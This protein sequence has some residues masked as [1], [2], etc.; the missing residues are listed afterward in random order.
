VNVRS[1]VWRALFD[2]LPLKVVSLIL[3]VTLFVIVRSDKDAA[4]GAFVKVVY[5]LPTDRVL[6]S[7]PPS[8]IKVAIRGS[9][10]RLQRFDEREI[11]PVRIDLSHLSD[12]VLRFDADLI[13][14][15]VGLRVGSIYPS[16]VRL[17]YEPRA[18]REVP[19]QAL[20]EGT[21]AEGFH[22]TQVRAVPA[23]IRIDGARR[24]VES[25]RRAPTRPV[26][27]QDAT[28]S[29][30]SPVAL[31]AP[32]A[33]VHFV[34][35]GPVTVE[36]EIRAAIIERTL[37]AVPVRLSGAQRI[38]GATDPQAVRVILRG[39]ADAVQKVDPAQ[40]AVTVEARV[41]DGRPPAT[42]KKRPQLSGLPAGV[43]AELRPDS[44]LI[45]TKRHHE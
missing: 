43:A 9:W 26:R 41:E 33:H 17:E 4:T 28:A 1:F 16:D 3:A 31:E 45:T 14:L 34:D 19:V 36:V 5:T 22:V 13:K 20:T 2:E 18:S 23:S 6:V 35:S 38:D 29:V 10:T 15:P 37:D 40:V 42:F 21:P 27:I 25:M 39:P 32:P 30:K 8:E 7:D 24:A 11:D 44:V 12:P